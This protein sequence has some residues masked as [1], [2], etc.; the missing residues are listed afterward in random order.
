[1]RSKSD[2]LLVGQTPPP[3]HGQAVMTAMLYDYEWDDLKVEKIRM[4][5]SDEVSSVGK[6]SIGKVFHLI[7]LIFQTWF[8]VFR[9]SPK[10]LYYLPASPNLTPVIRDFI[11]L[12]SVRWLFPKTVF[13][14]HAGGLDQYIEGKSWLKKL[15]KW[16]YNGAD[17]SIDVNVT[18]PPSG[19]YFH[20]K[21][22]V[23]VMNGLDVKS[24]V[25]DRGEGRFKV[26]SVGL[27]C[28]EKGSLELVK[29]AQK[30]KQQGHDCIWH[31]V[32]GWESE[33]FKE[34]MMKL[35]DELEVSDQIKFLG[36]LNGDSKWEA[37]AE[38][39]GFVFLSHHPTE[40]F[41]LVLI[42]AMGMGLPIITTKWR[43][44]P[45]VVG[46]SNAAI[47]CDIKSPDQFSS[48]IAELIS[49]PDQQSIMSENAVKYYQEHFTRA[50]F[51]ESIE[52]EFKKLVI[53]PKK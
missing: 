38:A 28:E 18:N 14:Y 30:L 52:S 4:G 53:E 8:V 22:N 51:I 43:G 20:A 19:E 42:E 6:A 26:I 10:V 44:I 21:K 25:V 49:A 5:F 48:A 46:E 7:S 41:G 36:V 29:T 37:Y 12:A 3:Y 47:L 23:V 40:T 27:L 34:E 24:M 9:K 32:G 11:Y 50:K 45:H 33:V 16:V 17:V 15:T 35:I 1:M 31:V 39:D 13:H 2:I